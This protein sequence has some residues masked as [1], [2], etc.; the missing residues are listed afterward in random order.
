MSS[1]AETTSPLPPADRPSA[2]AR[3]VV[4]TT[5]EYTGR[6]P[7]KARAYVNEP[8]V[9]VVLEDT[10][11]KA[12]HSLV[13]SGEAEIVITSRRAFQR[14]MREDLIA[15]VEAVMGRKVRAFLSDHDVLADIAVETFI[16][17][18]GS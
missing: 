5:A 12:E 18:E 13:A 1:I 10:L 8:I 6:G 2:L 7:T 15:G 16:L 11:T 17:E 14:T 3:L 4:R 9:C